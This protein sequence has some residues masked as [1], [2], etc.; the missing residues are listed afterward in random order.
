MWEPYQSVSSTAAVC[1]RKRGIW[2]GS[3]PFSFRGMTAKAPP[4]E[5]SQL[6]DRYSGLTCIV[7]MAARLRGEAR[8]LVCTLTR[9][10]SQALRL[11]W[12]LSYPWSF[13]VGFPKTCPTKLAR[14]VAAQCIMSLSHEAARR[15][16][17]KSSEDEKK[18]YD[19]STPERIDQ[20]WLR[21]L[22]SWG[23]VCWR[24]IKKSSWGTGVRVP[25]AKQESR[26]GGYLSG[27]CLMLMG[28]LRKRVA[29]TNALQRCTAPQQLPT[30][31]VISH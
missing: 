14:L 18:T 11:I 13:L 2:S 26:G 30:M 29:L 17:W 23:Q 20:P 21:W 4:P 25:E 24:L 15:A 19:I 12:R 28:L 7:S 1:P 31:A 8:G 9:F 3:L 27:T 16:G 22:P 5:A 10:V 6:T